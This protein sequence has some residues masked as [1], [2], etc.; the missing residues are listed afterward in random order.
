MRVVL[1]ADGRCQMLQPLSACP[2]TPAVG[3]TLCLLGAKRLKDRPLA[4]G[5]VFCNEPN[6]VT[7]ALHRVCLHEL[8]VTVAP[9]FKSHFSFTLFLTEAFSVLENTV[10]AYAKFSKQAQGEVV[11]WR[12]PFFI[13]VLCGQLHVSVVLPRIKEPRCT[14]NRRLNGPQILCERGEEKKLLSMSGFE[15]PIVQPAALSLYQLSY[16][17]CFT[18]YS[19]SLL[20]SFT[21]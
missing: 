21:E 12:H 5:F 2:F 20:S 7:F 1:S 14:S 11:V 6:R 17:G 9:Y 15:H 18:Q 4:S 13:M 10:R 8:P 19:V 3:S 16:S